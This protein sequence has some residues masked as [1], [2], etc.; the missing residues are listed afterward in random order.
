MPF[1]YDKSGLPANDRW[2]IA[3]AICNKW[4][5]DN[6]SVFGPERIA[7]FMANQPVA[8]AQ[9]VMQCCADWSDECVTILLLGPA[10]TAIVATPEAER[11]ARHI[12]GDRTVDLMHA[13]MDASYPHD[14]AMARDINR[15]FIAEGISTMSDQMIGRAR[16]DKHH[17][18]RW[19]ILNDLEKTFAT[20]KGQ[21]PALDAA[22]EDASAQ[23]R[24]ALEALDRAAAEKAKNNGKK[25]YNPP[26]GPR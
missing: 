11:V 1:D 19:N 2:K 4:L 16:I 8:A 25:P 26:A 6:M 7:N 22:F 23:S 9:R 14:A 15:I 3:A 21:D 24:K 20:V 10:K 13:M 5:D 12:F 17:Q 18:T